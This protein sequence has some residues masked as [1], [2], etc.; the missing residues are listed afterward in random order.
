MAKPRKCKNCPNATQKPMFWTFLFVKFI[1]IENI[2]VV[3]VIYVTVITHKLHY[4]T[5]RKVL[6]ELIMQTISRMIENEIAD[7]KNKIHE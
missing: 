4:V 5:I 7:K 1:Y 6:I 3:K 2:L